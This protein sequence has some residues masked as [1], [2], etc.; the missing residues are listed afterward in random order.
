MFKKLVECDSE[1]T[2]TTAASGANKQY[3]FLVRNLC[4]AARYNVCVTVLVIG[5][6]GDDTLKRKRKQN[7]PLRIL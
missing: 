2:K 4:I 7:I 3:P 6:N 5:K 1:R